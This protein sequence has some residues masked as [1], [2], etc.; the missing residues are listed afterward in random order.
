M[1]QRKK[2]LL[3]AGL[4]LLLL[5][6]FTVTPS[7]VSASV[8]SEEETITVRFSAYESINHSYYF[9]KETFTLQKPADLCDLL[10]AAKE[11]GLIRSFAVQE[12]LIIAVRY[13]DN[14]R[15]KNGSY[16]TKSSFSVLL[17]KDDEVRQLDALE[18]LSLR[19]GATYT[20]SYDAYLSDMARNTASA[21]KE[22]T[23]FWDDSW[24]VSLDTACR[25][26]YS[27]HTRG[28]NSAVTALGVA[29]RSATPEDIV[30]LT[31]LKTIDDSSVSALC[32]SLDACVY[33]GF[34]PRNIGGIDYLLRLCNMKQPDQCDTRVLCAVLRLYNSAD[35]TID[36]GVCLSRRAIIQTLLKR[37][38]EDGGF[39]RNDFSDADPLTTAQTLCALQSYR[40]LETVDSAVQN[41]ISFLSDPVL[42][43]KM[44]FG[45][46]GGSIEQIS[47]I[48]IA[49]CCCDLPFDD[50]YFSEAGITYAD[51]L[52]QYMKVSGGF[53]MRRG[54]AENEAATVLAIF[55]MQALKCG[56]D[57]FSVDD[58][59]LVAL[60]A[61]QQSIEVSALPQKEKTVA[62]PEKKGV[63]VSVGF[64][65]AIGFI[66]LY[67]AAE[68]FFLIRRRRKQE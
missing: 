47:W 15:L 16:G 51:L 38:Q 24:E 29:K 34:S 17:T 62:Q 66:M 63:K 58:A 54:G 21:R 57:P 4:L 11:R 50:I 42:R 18:T 44:F 22:T 41:G 36:D 20:L 56:G 10:C 23:F 9:Q 43:D 33:S 14:T 55:A 68:I 53:S 13:A 49:M 32:R 25:W 45:E 2:R 8:S 64:V 12:G 3:A 26:L 60:D 27:N 65:L 28:S 30:L 5:S 48:I 31:Q 67:L 35:F 39:A 61:P 1:L 7:A 40:D 52:L 19:D 46:S 59:T 6:I 37:Q